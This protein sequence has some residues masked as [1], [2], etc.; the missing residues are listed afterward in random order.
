[1]S[2]SLSDYSCCGEDAFNFNTELCCNDVV[3][4]V[5]GAV[6]DFRCCGLSNVYDITSELCCSGN[7]VAVAGNPANYVCCGDM[8]ANNIFSELCCSDTV[9]PVPGPSQNYNCCGDALAYNLNTEICCLGNPVPVADGCCGD[10]EYF[11]PATQI[12]CGGIVQPILG[13]DIS[14]TECCNGTSY[15]IECSVCEDDQIVS[16]VNETTHIC[17][18]GNKY[19]LIYDNNCCCG[20]QLFDSTLK[21]CCNDRIIDRPI[22]DKTACCGKCILDV[23]YGRQFEPYLMYISAKTVNPCQPAHSALA[24]MGRYFSQMH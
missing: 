17:C 21:V 8:A 16:I 23:L 7:P 13:N 12:C 14:L 9:V 3:K 15:H 11:D 18:Q 1:M 22:W 10:D 19:E 5:S 4:P 20:D 24:D 2:G 6:S